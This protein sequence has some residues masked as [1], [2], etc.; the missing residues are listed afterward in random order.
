MDF[1]FLGS[2]ATRLSI[3]LL[4]DVA[5]GR[6]NQV[7]SEIVSD[8]VASRKLRRNT[9]GKTAPFNEKIQSAIVAVWLMRFIMTLIFLFSVSSKCFVDARD[10]AVR[11]LK[12]M[13]EFV[14]KEIAWSGLSSGAFVEIEDPMTKRSAKT[15]I[16]NQRTVHKLSERSTASFR[17][18]MSSRKDALSAR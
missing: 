12:P 17:T 16:A 5:Q 7:D 1:V 3:Q 18:R 13:R 9:C 15:S 11:M 4:T 14:S 2:N 8:S 10:S 6:G